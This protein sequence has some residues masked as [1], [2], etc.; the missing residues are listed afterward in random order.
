MLPGGSLSLDVKLPNGDIVKRPYVL[1]EEFFPGSTSDSGTVT[2]EVVYVGFGTTAPELGYDD[3]AGVDVKGKLVMMEPESPVGPGNPAEFKKWRP[4]S[5]HDYKV[6]NAAK[7]GAVGLVYNYFIV[8][9]NCAF[10]KGF[11]WAAV[12]KTVW[13]DVF[14]GTGK[15][16]DELVAGIRKSLKPASFATGKVMTMK[17]V[18]E[19]HPEGIGSN[20]VAVIEGTDPV[21]KQEAI[22][23]GAHLDHLGLNPELMP[24]AHDN[25]SG[26]AVLL[27][28]AQALAS[29]GIPFKR[30][31]VFVIFGAEEQGVKGSESTSRTRTSPTGRRRRC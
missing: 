24:G 17:N 1:E 8:N 21:L 14:A 15:T 13:D 7:H 9:P 22:V 4:Y 6:Q 3:Y 12:G 10:V 23:I 20:V 26:V 11:A 2:A 5:F 25:A 18:T 19:H 28:A 27:G 31:I 30:S 16:H 29:S